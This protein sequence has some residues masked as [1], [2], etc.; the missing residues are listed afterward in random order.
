MNGLDEGKWIHNRYSPMNANPPRFRK[1]GLV[2][3]HFPGAIHAIIFLIVLV[4]STYAD[5]VLED[6]FSGSPQGSN[7]ANRTP[8][9]N[10][11]GIASNTWVW[12]SGATYLENGYV[13]SA[14]TGSSIGGRLKI[15]APSSLMET[16]AV[17]NLNTGVTDGTNPVYTPVEWAA[18]GFR[19]DSNTSWTSSGGGLIWGIVRPDGRWTL[20]Q[21]GVNVLAGST[22]DTQLPAFTLGSTTT[23]SIQY[24]PLTLQA[25]LFIDGLNIS[26]WQATSVVASSIV[27]AGFVDLSAAA[28]GPR[29][30]RVDTFNVSAIPEPGGAATLCLGIGILGLRQTRRRR[31]AFIDA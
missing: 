6:T 21:N 31:S 27:S 28:S 29:M 17:F 10:N 5:L 22:T 2:Q 1:S 20:F 25:A 11:A 24:D 8:T 3:N 18:V 19:T 12:W 4:P 14:V 30:F 7:P 13:I 26:G 15:N 16:S 9:T 23:L